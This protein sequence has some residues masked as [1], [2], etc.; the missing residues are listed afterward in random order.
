MTG[1]L[2]P[3]DYEFP[4]TCGEYFSSIAGDVLFPTLYPTYFMNIQVIFGES[5]IKDILYILLIQ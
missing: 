2:P 3:I 4:T 5:R 1:I